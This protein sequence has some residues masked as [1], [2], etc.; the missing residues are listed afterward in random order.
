MVTGHF[1]SNWPAEHNILSAR[2]RET[3][4]EKESV[5]RNIFIYKVHGADV[6]IEKEEEQ[7]QPGVTYTQC[8]YSAATIKWSHRSR[9]PCSNASKCILLI[10]IDWW[11]NEILIRYSLAVIA[12]NSFHN[13]HWLHSTLFGTSALPRIG[14]IAHNSNKAIEYIQLLFILSEWHLAVHQHRGTHTHTYFVALATAL[15]GRLAINTLGANHSAQSQITIYHSIVGTIRLLYTIAALQQQVKNS[16]G[17]N[18][19]YFS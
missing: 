12:I 13:F 17:C 7:Q 4:W 11:S 14:A 9:L 8:V 15:P 16:L 1:V 2:A 6:K 18:I 3:D 5:Y 10:T 19:L